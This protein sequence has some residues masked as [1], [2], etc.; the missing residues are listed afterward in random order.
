MRKEL[1]CDIEA[2]VMIYLSY[3]SFH[4]MPLNSDL[5]VEIDINGFML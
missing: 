4:R 3:L 1:V 2:V 5:T